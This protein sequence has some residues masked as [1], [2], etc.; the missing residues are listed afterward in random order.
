MSN[1]LNPSKHQIA[2]YLIDNIISD[3]TQY[4]ITDYGYTVEKALDTVYSSNML[5]IL[6][7]EDSELYVQS[8]S[9]NYEILKKEIGLDVVSS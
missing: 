4:L 9:Y 1:K 2:D 8:P 6:T 3:M 7:D 5:S